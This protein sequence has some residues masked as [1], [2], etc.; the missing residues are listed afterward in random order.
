MAKNLIGVV[1]SVA[2]Q[3]TITVTVAEHKVHPLYHKR[4]LSSQ[5]YLAHDEKSVAAIGDKV[6]IIE[7]RPIS[8]RKHFRLEQV[9]QAAPV[10]H[11]ETPVEIP[12]TEKAK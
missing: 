1:S 8:K 5:K 12:K 7:T 3:K 2:A 11:V 10:R 6:S 4:Y 9:I